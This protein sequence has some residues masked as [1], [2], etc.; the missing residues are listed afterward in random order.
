MKHVRT[1]LRVVKLNFRMHLV[2]FLYIELYYGI[3]IK[4]SVG[5]LVLVEKF[6]KLFYF[7]YLRFQITDKTLT[8]FWQDHSSAGMQEIFER[9]TYSNYP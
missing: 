1:L 7:F 8:K 2:A 3:S 6:K 9:K 4:N 5:V